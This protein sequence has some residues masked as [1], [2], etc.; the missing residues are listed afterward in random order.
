MPECAEAHRPR[1]GTTAGW[2]VPISTHHPAA[3]VASGHDQIDAV[4]H[5]RGTQRETGVRAGARNRGRAARGGLRLRLSRTGGADN[6]QSED[7]Y[8]A[9]RHRE[10]DAEDLAEGRPVDVH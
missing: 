2:W 3:S 8:D 10:A 1:A 7:S 6:A 9:D 4:R 5:R